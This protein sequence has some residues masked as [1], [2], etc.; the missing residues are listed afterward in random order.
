MIVIL[1]SMISMAEEY[2]GEIHTAELDRREPGKEYTHDKITLTG[3]TEEGR[4]Y[5]LELR[6]EDKA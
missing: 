6:L 2:V 5:T 3:I 4:E 1:K